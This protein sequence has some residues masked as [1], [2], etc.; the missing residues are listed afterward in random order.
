MSQIIKFIHKFN[1]KHIEQLQALYQVEWWARDR[2]LEETAKCVRE[3]QVCIGIVSENG[4]LVGFVRVLIDFTFKA[5]LFDVI[6]AR[7]ERGKGL[8][9]KLLTLI[10]NH[11]KLK[12]VKTFELYCLP[13]M[14]SFYERHGF[15]SHVGEIKLMRFANT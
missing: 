1:K 7:S 12:W 11:E 8:G 3:S 5:L 10:T 4:D 9:N 14:F 2:T 13:E 15:S 6:V